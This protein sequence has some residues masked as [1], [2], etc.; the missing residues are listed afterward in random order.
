MTAPHASPLGPPDV[1]TLLGGL[2]RALLED[3][4]TDLGEDWRRSGRDT[5][6]REKEAPPRQKLGE[7][8]A[9]G[10]GLWEQNYRSLPLTQLGPACPSRTRQSSKDRRGHRNR[11]G[12]AEQEGGPHGGW[13]AEMGSKEGFLEKGL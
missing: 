2:L 8:A 13:G 7:G 10:S 3:G 6:R 11:A 9:A 4:D 1:P 12:R 5:E